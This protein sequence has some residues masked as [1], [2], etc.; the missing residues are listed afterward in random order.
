MSWRPHPITTGFR[1]EPR[2]APFWADFLDDAHV[3]VAED[4]AR[5]G[6]GAALVHVQVR[7]ADVGGG[8]AN[9]VIRRRLYASIFGSG[10]CSTVALCGSWCTTAFMRSP[11]E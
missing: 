7:A 9:D 4:E 6:G 2:G 1:I 5:L 11:S 10:I 8:N 3:L